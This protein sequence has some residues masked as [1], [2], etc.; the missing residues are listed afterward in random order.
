ML[1]EYALEVPSE[2]DISGRI[3]AH[4]GLWTSLEDQNSHSALKKAFVNGYSVETDV[5]EYLGRIVV[6]HDVLSSTTDL[7]E[8]VL[9]GV[10]RFALNIK[11]DG[12]LDKFKIYRDQMLSSDS[13][14]FDGSIPEMYKARTIGFPH[15]LRMSEF[16]QE[17]PWKS[18]YL[19]IDGFNSEW[20]LG[21]SRINSLAEGS[22][23]VFVSPEL[24]GR[25]HLRAFDW[26]A[27]INAKGH[28]D[29]SVCTDFPLELE[30]Y[31]NG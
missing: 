14:L 1:V 23:L 3:F 7:H 31:L 16:E 18:D 10:D 22:R 9:N 30:N 29:F 4:R 8:L 11:Q 13:F 25:D 2:T 28:F 12:M 20:W 24:H 15:A 5:R 6:S 27:E 19:W 21:D 26:F 17:V